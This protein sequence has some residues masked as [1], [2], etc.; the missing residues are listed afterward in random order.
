MLDGSW[1]RRCWNAV[2]YQSSSEHRPRRPLRRSRARRWGW[3]RR[4]RKW[5]R[6][7]WRSQWRASGSRRCLSRRSSA[8]GTAR[9][10]VGS[11]R[12]TPA[13][14]APTPS[15]SAAPATPWRPSAR[16]PAVC[17]SSPAPSPATTARRRPPPSS[18]LGPAGYALLRGGGSGLSC[19]SWTRLPPRPYRPRA[20][21]S[22]E[23]APSSSAAWT[24]SWAR[25][26][27]AARG[28]GSWGSRARGTAPGSAASRRGSCGRRRRGGKTSP[29]SWRAPRAR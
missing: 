5:R 18:P 20:S 11:G 6:R 28:C 9:L 7:R 15:A 4:G 27:T 16:A 29:S 3:G 1:T 24:R 2:H 19:S 22:G 23:R 21:T 26:P 13:P 25:W 12:P 10:G 17:S 8:A 14:S